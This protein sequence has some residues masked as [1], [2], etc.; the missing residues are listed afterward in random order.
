MTEGTETPQ[1]Y[2]YKSV[3]TPDSIALLQPFLDGHSKGGWRLAHTFVSSGGY[4]VGLI[5]ERPVAKQQ[6]DRASTLP[7]AH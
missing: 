2:E 3:A 4:T 5:F 6:P 7:N 1:E